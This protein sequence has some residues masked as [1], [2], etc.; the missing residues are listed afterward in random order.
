MKSQVN[1]E[2][3]EEKTVNTETASEMKN[4]NYKAS[5]EHQKIQTP[6]YTNNCKWDKNSETTD[7]S[8]KD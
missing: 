8:S 7:E 3:N 6:Y 1:S 5:K 4:D 2:N